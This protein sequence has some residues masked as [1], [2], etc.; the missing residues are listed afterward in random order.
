MRFKDIFDNATF[1]EIL[2]FSDI[3][4]NTV[5]SKRKF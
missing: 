2:Q 1:H 3:C 5:S 4:A